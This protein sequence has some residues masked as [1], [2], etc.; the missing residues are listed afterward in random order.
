MHYARWTRSP[1][2]GH[3][4]RRGPQ[5]GSRAALLAMLGRFDE[6]WPLVEARSRHLR[7]VTGDTSREAYED[8]ALIATIQGDLERACHAT[9]EAMKLIAHVAVPA[10]TATA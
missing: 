3:R 4:R 2:G 1:H 7:E 5:A 6:A 10:A 9:A 8:I